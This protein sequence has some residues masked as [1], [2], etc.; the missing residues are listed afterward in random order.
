MDIIDYKS[1]GLASN[2]N[3][4]EAVIST[5]SIMLKDVCSKLRIHA[6]DEKDVR[7]KDDAQVPIGPPASGS[8]T[9][10]T[11][12]YRKDVIDLDA[13]HVQRDSSSKQSTQNT[14]VRPD[15]AAQKKSSKRQ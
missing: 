10:R 9:A 12:S 1:S 6:S 4:K 14:S 11:G 7:G 5:E 2:R 3:K 15:Q 8:E 13:L